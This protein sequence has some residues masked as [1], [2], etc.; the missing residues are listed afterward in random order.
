MI[1]VNRKVLIQLLALL[2]I[3]VLFFIA[4][5]MV[6]PFFMVRYHVDKIIHFLT[7]GL[8]ALILLLQFPGRG[9]T[10]IVAVSILVGVLWEL[11]E[12]IGVMHFGWP[13]V[14]FMRRSY[15]MD[16]FFD[17][18]AVGLGAYML[19]MISKIRLSRNRLV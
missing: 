17:E 14:D 13:R 1:L 7:G 18:L 19:I 4:F 16:T 6:D 12:Y 3:G 2:L 5:R 8:V 9:V 11:V 10:K 15:F